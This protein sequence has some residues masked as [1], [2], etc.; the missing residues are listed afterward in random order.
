MCH[1]VSNNCQRPPTRVEQPPPPAA[2]SPER[3][4]AGIQ[5]TQNG[6]PYNNTTD[7]FQ[8]NGVNKQEAKKLEKFMKKL[9]KFIE[10]VEKFMPQIGDFL[11][12]MVSAI[13]REKTPEVQDIPERV[14]RA[15]ALPSPR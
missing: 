5:S 7:T 11:R 15:P 12:D 14:R 6:N 3:P 10:K 8:R 2:I 4:T 1:K 13:K 9:E